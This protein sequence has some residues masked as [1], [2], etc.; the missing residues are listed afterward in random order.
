MQ[1]FGLRKLR[2]FW[3]LICFD[4]LEIWMSPIKKIRTIEMEEE[5]R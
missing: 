5:G 3:Y 2:I 1:N 4:G